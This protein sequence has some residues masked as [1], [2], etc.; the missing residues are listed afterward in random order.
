M[1]KISW[2]KRNENEYYHL[3]EKHIT[4]GNEI[5]DSA[6]LNFHYDCTKLAAAAI[7]KLPKTERNVSGMTL[8]ISR[9]VYEKICD[10]VREFRSTVVDIVEG[11]TGS[12]RVYQ[13]NIHL[14]PL[15]RVNC[16]RETKLKDENR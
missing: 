10:A 2:I 4:T 5:I 11:D 13:L 14:F 7:N 9:Q 8:G 12:D 3:T 1:R 6:A 16:R 15:S